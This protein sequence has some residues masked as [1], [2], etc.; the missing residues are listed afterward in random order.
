MK[1]SILDNGYEWIL[2]K[3]WEMGA[4]IRKGEEDKYRRRKED[5]KI[6]VR[7]EKR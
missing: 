7:Y 2:L 4:L 3:E 5:N 1:I 6:S